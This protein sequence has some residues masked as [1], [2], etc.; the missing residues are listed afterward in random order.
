[1]AKDKNEKI[2]IKNLLSLAFRLL[3]FY[4]ICKS[5]KFY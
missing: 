2:V 3:P 5:Q 4:Y 1:M